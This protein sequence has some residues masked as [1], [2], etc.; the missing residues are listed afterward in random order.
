MTSPI[1]LTEA[2][3]RNACAP[4]SFERG[5]EYYHSGA[6]YNTARVGNSLLG[7]CEGTSVPSYRVQ[8]GLDDAGVHSAVC[9][10]SYDWGGHC[11]HIV[12]LLLTYIHKPELFVERLEPEDLLAPLSREDLVQLIGKLLRR[13]PDLCDWLEAE[14]KKPQGKAKHT[15]TAALAAQGY[16]RQINAI[17]HSLDRMRPSQAYWHMDEM[18]ER[19]REV[20]ESAQR[21]LENGDAQSALTI[22]M[23]LTEE[24]SRQFGVMDDSNG[25][26][27]GFVEDLGL[28]LAEAILSAEL[29]EKERE[30]ISNKLEELAAQLSDYG[31]EATLEVAIA[32]VVRG[33]SGGEA[34]ARGSVQEREEDEGKWEAWVSASLNEAKLNVLERRGEVEAYLALASSTGR[35]TRYAA[36]LLDIGRTDEGVATAM[37]HLTTAEEALVIA[38]RLRE[39]GRVQEAIR[40]GEHGLSLA[41]EKYEL[42]RWLGPLEEGCGY[43]DKALHAYL[44]G[45]AEGPSLSDYSTIQRLAGPTWNDLKP[46]VVEMLRISHNTDA[47]ADVLLAEGEWDAA[48][49]VADGKKGWGYSSLV[50]KV[51]DAV[52]PHRPDWVIKVCRRQAEELIETRQSKHYGAAAHWLTKMKAVFVSRGQEREWK[53]YLEELRNKYSRRPALQAELRRL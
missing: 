11:K 18:V 6:I 44:V 46:K 2:M 12:A 5:Q 49:G 33:W 27:G 39:L 24:V 48:I 32:A 21:F 30:A 17:L 51:A 41:G 36:K 8:V 14:I 23:T 25:T 42:A 7:E 9:T 20:Q 38:Q 43:S 53:D 19:L 13:Q 26:L 4:Q 37:A 40:L 15:R 45:F 1:N 52:V 34:D 31:I 22:L 28:P 47:L 16:R 29:T 10:C 35:Y 50:E 3:I